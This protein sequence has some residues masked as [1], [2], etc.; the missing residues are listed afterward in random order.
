[1]RCLFQVPSEG[2]LSIEKRKA[3]D[4]IESERKRKKKKNKGPNPRPACSWVHFRY[5][6]SLK[7]GFLG[8]CIFALG[9]CLI[10]EFLV[11]L[12]AHV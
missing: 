8:V 4:D 7:K 3:E 12:P 2:D 9:L 11:Q 6:H 5:N 1:M 10:F